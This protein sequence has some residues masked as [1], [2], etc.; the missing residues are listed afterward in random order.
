MAKKNEVLQLDD[1]VKQN[2]KGEVILGQ[3]YGPCADIINPTRNGRK[4]DEAL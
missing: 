2:S 1:T 4:Y 3:L